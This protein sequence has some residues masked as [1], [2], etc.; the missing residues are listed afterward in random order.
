[1]LA[2][3]PPLDRKEMMRMGRSKC[4]QPIAKVWEGGAATMEHAERMQ[5]ARRVEI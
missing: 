2:D 1:M 3:L 5:R 4:A